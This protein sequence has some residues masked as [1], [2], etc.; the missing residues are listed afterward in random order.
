MY[1]DVRHKIQKCHTKY[2]GNLRTLFTNMYQVRILGA[3]YVTK[4]ENKLGIWLRKLW[5]C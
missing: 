2:V 4:Y 1:S 5:L 3:K